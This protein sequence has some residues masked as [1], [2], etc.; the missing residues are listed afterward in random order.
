[1]TFK[2]KADEIN[3]VLSEPNVNLWKLRELALTEGG[4]VNGRFDLF[5]TL[6]GL[7]TPHLMPSHDRRVQIIFGNAHGQSWLGCMIF[8]LSRCIPKGATSP[9][10][11]Q[12]QTLGRRH[13][14]APMRAFKRHSLMM[15]L[16]SVPQCR[17]TCS[18]GTSK[19]LISLCGL[20]CEMKH[21][22]S[23]SFPHSK[24][25]GRYVPPCLDAEQIER[26]VCRCTWHL[27]TGN[28]RITRLKMEN[29][30]RK[31]VANMLKKKQRRLGKLINLTLLRTYEESG[32]G[33]RLCYY[34]GYHDVASIFMSTL[35]G[36][37][38]SPSSIGSES[39]AG[40]ASS[41]GLD[42]PSAVLS[43]LSSTH[44]R[45]AMRSNFMQLQT[46]I[47]LL[48]MPLISYFDRE[49]HEFLLDCDMEPYFA[50]S[51]IITWFSHDIRDTALVKRLF[52][53]FI[54]SHPLLPLYMTVAMVCHPNNRAE[55]LAAECDF[56]IV[57][58]TLAA[59]PKNSSMVGW[60]YRPSEGGYT[61]GDETDDEVNVSSMEVSLLLEQHYSVEGRDEDESETHSLIS[62]QISIGSK[63]T[64]V[65]FQ[66]LIDNA[67]VF[68]RRVPPRKLIRLTEMYYEK[69]TLKPMLDLRPS[70]EF[71]N[72]HPKWGLVLTAPADW[73][74]KQRSR[75]LRDGRGLTRRDRRNRVR[76]RSPSLTL[77]DTNKR[78][79]TDDL[80]KTTGDEP[81]V[82]NEDDEIAR[83]LLENKKM[84]AVIACGFGAGDEEDIM[85]RKR[86]RLVL[87]C[88][89]A[90]VVIISVAAI[91]YS[92]QHS[93]E[94]QQQQKEQHCRIGTD[95][96]KVENASQKLSD[97]CLPSSLFIENAKSPTVSMAV[98]DDLP[99]RLRGQPRDRIAT[100]NSIV[101][102]AMKS[103]TPKEAS[104]LV[105]PKAATKAVKTHLPKTSMDI[106][107][108]DVSPLSITRAGGSLVDRMLG[109]L[110][111]P[112]F[113]RLVKAYTDLTLEKF[114]KAIRAIGRFL[115]PI[116]RNI[117]KKHVKDVEL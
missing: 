27:L 17:V 78:S 46:A 20:S 69:E 70:I 66:E 60:K 85:D 93:S 108:R 38:S 106:G 94:Q 115:Q 76:S 42:L 88:V 19:S 36:G 116:L 98:C 45:D 37:G 10:A 11:L 105:E 109:V 32:E 8:M 54:V 112:N 1:M 72:P 18:K 14:L 97:V 61:S 2:T 82:V 4:L 55:V 53:A 43:R 16:L 67:L 89:A 47:R 86:R 74:L 29:K 9:L 102:S 110:P 28:Q 111:C 52:D 65:P 15:T 84:L 113:T 100:E 39:A 50:L 5:Y 63:G 117:G 71:L 64:K 21:N 87:G 30:H 80:N 59:L 26:D 99:T 40:I 114:P 62:S 44:F 23:H 3:L 25:A 79:Q 51:W 48:L 7:S 81:A 104:F 22:Q 92:G 68:M 33:D 73:V 41:I 49:V 91:V 96:C 13:I 101:N 103:I 12:V 107:V 75:R 83:F 58:S 90:A 31:K 35:G 57:H 34:Q 95:T 24:G 56:A 6:N 77:D